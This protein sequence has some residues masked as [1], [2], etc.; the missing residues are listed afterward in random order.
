M[1]LPKITNKNEYDDKENGGRTRGREYSWGTV[2]IEN[3][4]KNIFILILNPCSEYNRKPGKYIFYF[5]I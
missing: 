4:V 3:P 2:N 1:R 5:H